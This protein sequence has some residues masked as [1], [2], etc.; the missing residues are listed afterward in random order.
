M[1]P[2]VRALFLARLA[3]TRQLTSCPLLRLIRNQFE[4][5]DEGVQ[6]EFES[7]LDERGINSS[8]ALFIPDLAEFKCVSPAYL[9]VS[10]LASLTLASLLN[11]TGSR[12]MSSSSA[13]QPALAATPP[14]LLTTTLPF[15]HRE[16]VSW[17]KSVN[18]FIEA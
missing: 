18:S 13:L 15:L 14:R 6:A 17:L 10:E 7:F 1:G 11:L 4:N 12:S 9:S 16:Y 2:A 3:Q 5:L 8:L